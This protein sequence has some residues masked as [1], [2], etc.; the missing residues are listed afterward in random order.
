MKK[1]VVIGAGGL[2]REVIE[3]FNEQNKLKKQWDII[4]F[5]DETPELQGKKIHNFPILGGFDWIENNKCDVGFVVAVGDPKGKKQIVKRLESIGVFFFNV[6][7]P[8]V[9]M[10]DYVKM[11]ID[12]IICAGTILTVDIVIANHV[13]INYNSTIGHDVVI[14]EYCSIMP[15]VSISGN[16]ILGIG[17]FVGT[18][19]RLIEKITIGQWTTIGAGSVII[20]DIPSDVTVVGV[21]AK[22][23]KTLASLDKS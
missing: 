6:I 23:I 18:G 11:G 14:N 15:N 7:H 12:I 16:D 21:P 8:T 9:I 3:I 13:I 22:I 4:G 17:V 2:G 5:V 1:V 10:S 20:K 19:A